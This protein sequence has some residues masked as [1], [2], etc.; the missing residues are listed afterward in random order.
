V[1][2]ARWVVLLGIAVTSLAC[3]P[4]PT[5]ARTPT[6]TTAGTT[7]TTA[8][9]ARGSASTR[10][11]TFASRQSQPLYERALEGMRAIDSMRGSAMTEALAT[12]LGFKCADL[13]DLR[14]RLQAE[15]DP[16]VWRLRSSIDKT[17]G[18]DVPIASALLELDRIQKK[19]AADATADLSAECRI[20][21]LALAD[22]GTGYLANPT[23]SDVIGKDS[24]YCGTTDSVRRLP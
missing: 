3:D 11:P 20:L 6:R 24:M 15:P 5:T 21:K 22:L 12:D 1:I 2:P 7:T 14:G 23:A 8:G 9:I 4:P 16:Q 10:A 17:C 13:K 19:R 18:Y